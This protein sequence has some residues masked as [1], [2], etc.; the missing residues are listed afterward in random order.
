MAD[1]LLL[2][3]GLK[4]SLHSALDIFNGIV[5][6]GIDL[7]VNPL[8]LCHILGHGI[9][10]HIKA[11]DDRVRGRRQHDIRFRDSSDASMNHLDDHFII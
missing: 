9:R 5:D 3:D 2:I 10:A 6:N 7:N 11:D 1:H 4:H 8:V